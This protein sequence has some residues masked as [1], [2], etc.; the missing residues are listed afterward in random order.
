MRTR[1]TNL[2][3]SLRLVKPQPK[4]QLVCMWSTHEIQ[5]GNSGDP[6]LW[7]SA[8]FLFSWVSNWSFVREDN[9]REDAS[10]TE[11]SACEGIRPRTFTV[12][13]GADK[14]PLDAGLAGG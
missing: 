5:T 2:E 8:V 13:A 12:T 11:I 4:A 9:D 7:S 6:G 14:L 3:A 1:S 10:E